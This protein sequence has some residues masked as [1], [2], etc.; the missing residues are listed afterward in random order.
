MSRR[1]ALLL[2][3]LLA[4]GGPTGC[5][6]EPAPPAVSA[7]GWSTFGAPVTGRTEVPARELLA[8]PAAFVGKE[9]VVT[10]RVADVCS[11]AG[12]W[13]VI[14]EGDQTM[15]VRMKDHG[16]SVA[17][18]GAGSDCRVQGT[19]VAIEVDPETVAHFEGE[20]RKPGLM[21][22]KRA[23]GGMVYELVASGVALRPAG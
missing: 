13:M 23:E 21:P 4:V 6:A 8:E 5:G 16:F 15:R 20:S 3:G 19:V 12:C 10:G 9:L 18:D 7:D 22:E 17:K 2:V 14:A 11:K 1:T